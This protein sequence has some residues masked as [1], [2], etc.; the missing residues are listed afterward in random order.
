MCNRELPS[1][2]CWGKQLSRDFIELGV[3]AAEISVNHQYAQRLL[4]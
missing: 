4:N 1:I 3:D 2:R